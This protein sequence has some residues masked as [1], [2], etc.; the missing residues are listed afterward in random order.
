M[1][2]KGI[3]A[4]SDGP[5]CP[6]S[7]LGVFCLLPPSG[8]KIFSLLQTI[9]LDSKSLFFQKG[10]WGINRKSTRQDMGATSFPRESDFQGKTLSGLSVF[11][12][13]GQL[14]GMKTEKAVSA[15]VYPGR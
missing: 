1:N 12:R 13:L 2:D 8:P 4:Q 6:L 15:G 3:Q 9:Q 5:R 7:A 10:L 11:V 14:F